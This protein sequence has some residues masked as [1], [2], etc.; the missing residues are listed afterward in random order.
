MAFRDKNSRIPPN[1][2]EQIQ[3]DRFITINQETWLNQ[4]PEAKASVQRGLEQAAAGDGQYLGS[5]AQYADLEI[6]DEE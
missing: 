6:D 4:N 1:E 2:L 5:F 3:S